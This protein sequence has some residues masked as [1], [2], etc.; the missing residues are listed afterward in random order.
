MTSWCGPA[1]RVAESG[2]APGWLLGGLGEGA[3][4]LGDGHGWCTQLAPG[5]WA[6]PGLT[7][8]GRPRASL[9]AP[10]VSEYWPDFQ[11]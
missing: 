5:D 4:R 6:C 9:S 11:T 8:T 1:E 2:Q 10:D 7:R 3:L